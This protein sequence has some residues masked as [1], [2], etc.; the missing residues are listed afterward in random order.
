MGNQ[1]HVTS[2]LTGALNRAKVSDRKVV[3]MLTE[4]SRALGKN[5]EELNINR[6]SIHREHMK[7]HSQIAN[8]LK[9]EFKTDVPLIIHW[10]G[11]LERKI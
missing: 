10:D 4:T 8:K 6:S 3:F 5:V 1:K 2:S 11:K 9:D 7:H